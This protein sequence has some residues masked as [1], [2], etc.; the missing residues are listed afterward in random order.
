[1]GVSVQPRTPLRAAGA[2]KRVVEVAALQKP[3]PP[4]RAASAGKRLVE[5]AALQKPRRPLRAASA[6]KRVFAFP[7]WRGRGRGTNLLMTCLEKLAQSF[8]QPLDERISPRRRGTA[9]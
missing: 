6:G 2:G 9:G 5:V 4:L 3:R 8:T 1:M 7:E